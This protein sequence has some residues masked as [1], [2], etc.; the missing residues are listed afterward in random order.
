MSINGH[1][2]RH[3]SSNSIIILKDNTNQAIIQTNNESQINELDLSGNL[4]IGDNKF[5]V[6]ISGNVEID[7][8]LNVDG[9]ITN[10]Y[11]ITPFSYVP[12]ILYGSSPSNPTQ[13]NGVVYDVSNATGYTISNG[14][15]TFCHLSIIITLTDK[16]T[17]NDNHFVYVTMPSNPNI[18]PINDRTWMTTYETF[19][20][21]GFGGTPR[22]YPFCYIDISN[23]IIV[24][25]R[26]TPNAN[27]PELQLLF[28]T[29]RNTSRIVITF[30]YEVDTS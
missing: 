10:N 28:Q 12:S 14:D 26:W 8:D 13:A 15:K 23:N 5:D 2:I 6:D 4:R 11:E 3:E 17:A 16:G 30:F 22:R 21:G 29:I 18:L 20:V 9:I 25:S 19:N 1:E 24:L 27:D 7:G